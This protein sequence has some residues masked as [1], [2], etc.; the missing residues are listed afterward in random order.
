[1]NLS[2]NSVPQLLPDASPAFLIEDESDAAVAREAF[3]DAVA[4]VRTG[5][6]LAD[7]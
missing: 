3:L 7:S 1:M 2:S 5:T 6:P 4:S